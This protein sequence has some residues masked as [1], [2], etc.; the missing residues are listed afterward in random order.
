MTTVRVG[1]G[2]YQVHVCNG[3]A[4]VEVTFT[5]EETTLGIRPTDGVG[6]VV[7]LDASESVRL[8]FLLGVVAVVN[9]GQRLRDD[10]VD[11]LERLR[12]RASR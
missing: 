3:D 9:A 4:L 1:T 11:Q 2:R 8:V 7:D 10:A 6:Y 5:S 12:R